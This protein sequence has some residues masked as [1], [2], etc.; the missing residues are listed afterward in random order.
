MLFKPPTYH[1]PII[2]IKNEQKNSLPY[3]LLINKLVTLISVNKANFIIANT[4]E[5]MS[6]KIEE[7]LSDLLLSSG[8]GFHC[9]VS[10]KKNPIAHSQFDAVIKI[11]MGDKILNGAEMELHMAI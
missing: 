6:V 7:F 1:D 8:D 9:A 3:Q 2:N 4:P 11:V 10:I 5:G